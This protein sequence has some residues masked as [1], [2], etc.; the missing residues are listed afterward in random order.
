MK[1][2]TF[3]I[4]TA[5]HLHLQWWLPFSVLSLYWSMTYSTGVLLIYFGGLWCRPQTSYVLPGIRPWTPLGGLSTSDPSFV[6]FKKSLDYTMDNSIHCKV[7]E[8]DHHPE[9]RNINVLI[10][11][12]QDFDSLPI[13]CHIGLSFTG[14][15][16]QTRMKRQLYHY[17]ATTTPRCT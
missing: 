16:R 11:K 13:R 6:E 1:S 17:A 14:M 8:S 12:L 5:L 3:G 4:R 15:H 10:L 2:P 7:C 9:C